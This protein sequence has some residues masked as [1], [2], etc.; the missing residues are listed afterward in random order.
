MISPRLEC[1][2]ISL[3]HHPCMLIACQFQCIEGNFAAMAMK[4]VGTTLPALPSLQ[5]VWIHDERLN[6]ILNMNWH[7]N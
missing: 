7:L 4:N 6:K 5:I 1:L 2:V 3:N